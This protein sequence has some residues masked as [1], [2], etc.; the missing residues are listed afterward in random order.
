MLIC[1][2]SVRISHDGL[3]VLILIVTVLLIVAIIL[4]ELASCPD[5]PS[6]MFLST[7]TLPPHQCRPT[8]LRVQRTG[9]THILELAVSLLPH[10]EHTSCL[11][12][13][14]LDCFKILTQRWQCHFL[15]LEG[16]RGLKL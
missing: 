4:L 9:P 1:Y 11:L 8:S 5:S 2:T 6:R 7:F 13:I 14:D 12:R 16:D 10:L 3:T 15:R